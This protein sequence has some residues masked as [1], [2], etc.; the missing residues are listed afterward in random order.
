MKLEPGMQVRIITSSDR[1]YKGKVLEVRETGWIVM[2]LEL[3][4]KVQINPAH[5]VAI[6]E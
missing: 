4:E 1:L 6:E 3:G 2:A 5:I